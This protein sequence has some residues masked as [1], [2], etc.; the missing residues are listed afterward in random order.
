MDRDRWDDILQKD[1][2]NQDGGKIYL[3]QAY[4]LV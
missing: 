3:L 2:K 1:Q 4:W